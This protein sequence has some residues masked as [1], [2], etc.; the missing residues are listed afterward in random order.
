MSSESLESR[1]EDLEEK[2]GFLLQVRSLRE[3]ADNQLLSAI[4]ETQADHTLRLGGIEHRLDEVN[5]KVGATLTAV[6]M[7]RTMIERLEG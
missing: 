1:I 7:I 6:L 3:A 2:V 5:D 4:R